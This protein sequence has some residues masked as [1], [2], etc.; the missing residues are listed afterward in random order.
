M[1]PGVQ[2]SMTWL[3][4]LLL[5]FPG[6]LCSAWCL[7]MTHHDHEEL[8]IDDSIPHLCDSHRHHH[9]CSHEGDAGSRAIVYEIQSTL[10]ERSLERFASTSEYSAVSLSDRVYF[11][12]PLPSGIPKLSGRE[13]LVLLQRFLI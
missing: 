13:T 10:A 3:L 11:H 4:M 12:L 9:C 6:C 8:Q 5:T 1:F 7:G 2:R